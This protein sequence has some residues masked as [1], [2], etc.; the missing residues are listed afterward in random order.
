MRGLFLF[1][2]AITVYAQSLHSL[3]GWPMP[4][5]AIAIE[6]P[7]E[8]QKPFSVAGEHGAVFGQQKGTFE[9]WAFPVK[10]LSDFRIEAHLADYPV[11]IDVNEYAAHIE[12]NPEQTTITYSHAAFTIRQHMFS[13]RGASVDGTG[14]VVLFEIESIRP[15]ELTFRFTPEMLRMWPASN[16]GR[17]NAEW[18]EQGYYLLHTDTD[19]LT[20]AVGIP[21]AQPGIM[22]PYQERPKT[23]PVELKLRFDPKVDAGRLFPLLMAVGTS[24][25]CEQRIAALNQQTPA[26]YRATADYYAHFFDTR[27]TVESPDPRFD[28]AIKWAEISI[29]QAQ[30]KHGAETGLVA[31]Y[32]SSGDSARPGFG[33]F[34][35]RD[36]EWSLYAVNS[37]GDFALTRTALDFLFRRQRDDGKIMHEYS[38][39]AEELDWKATPY[40]YASADSTPLLVMIMEDYVNASG[41]TAYL[42]QH[43]DAIKKAYAFTRKQNIYGNADGT[44]W[45]ESWPGGMPK[46]EIY[47][48]ALDQQSS[49]SMAHLAA[50]MKDDDLARKARE[51]AEQIRVA[52]PAQYLDSASKFFAFSRNPD[53]SKDLTPTIYPA[54]AWWTGTLSLPDAGPMLERWASHEF[55]TDWGTRDVSAGSPIYDPISYH[56]GSVW[57]L[58]TGWVSMAEFRAGQPI[59]ARQHLYQDLLLTWAQ[60]L[61]ACTELLS[62]AFYQPMGR[63]SSHQ[64]WS[65]AMVLTPAIRGLLGLNWDADG[66]LT[67]KPNLP[68]D[69]DHVHAHSDRIDIEIKRENG[70]LAI[71]HNGQHSTLP[72]PPVEI[73]LDH[74]APN[75]GAETEQIKALFQDAHSVTFEAMG[76]A[77]YDLPLRINQPGVAINGGVVQGNHLHI[78]FEGTGWVRKSVTW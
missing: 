1:F 10:I 72:L 40:F 53:G 50:L 75:P 63:S 77:S 24:R 29:D 5:S 52:I 14:A 65:S 6:S 70:V 21:G 48:A 47:M 69:W 16:F 67:I 32:Y 36:T 19:A 7:A 46:Q 33:W 42:A 3:S 12:V 71:T 23:Y 78:V 56:Q 22:A 20:G 49:H 26:L 37:Y 55:S 62:G 25:Q 58:F 74:F 60:D 61:G 68:P 43:W 57:P 39:M 13:P 27:L 31:G 59:A 17:P 76:G 51:K 73:D 9:A 2:S 45:V 15:I 54:V 11:P 18:R 64:L 66:K 28:R 38:Q 34:F 4:P 8:S 44:G 35:G 30:V 41:D